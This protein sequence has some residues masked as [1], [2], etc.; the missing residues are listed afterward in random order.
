MSGVPRNVGVRGAQPHVLNGPGPW[1]GADP[2][3][4]HLLGPVKTT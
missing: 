3:A 1:S 4:I 2:E